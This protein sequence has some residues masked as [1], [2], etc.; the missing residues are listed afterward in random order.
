MQAELVDDS[1][2][3]SSDQRGSS[4]QSDDMIPLTQ[5]ADD[6]DADN[7]DELFSS[8]DE[9]YT[10]SRSRPSAADRSRQQLKV[11]QITSASGE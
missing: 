1:T 5:N 11:D 6:D 7:G 4:T 8:D 3:H 2:S 9:R 10:R